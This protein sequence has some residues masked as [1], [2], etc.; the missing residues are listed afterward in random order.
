MHDRFVRFVFK[1][2]VPTTPE[3]RRRIIVHLLQLFLG[4]T[5]FDTSFNAIRSEW[6]R[7]LQVPFI[8]DGFLDF[9]DTTNEIIETLRVYTNLSALS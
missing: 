4:R 6:A 2:R 8:V 1:V 3:V 5:D 9:R 7:T